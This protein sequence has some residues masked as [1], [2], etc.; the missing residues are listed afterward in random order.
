MLLGLIGTLRLLHITLIF[1]SQLNSITI[2]N[3]LDM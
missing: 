2:D 3:Q 1:W